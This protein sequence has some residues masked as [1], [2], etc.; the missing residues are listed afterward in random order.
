[1]E[2]V[3]T[4]SP[5]MF[6]LPTRA[7]DVMEVLHGHLSA[8]YPMRAEDYQIAGG[9]NYSDFK[10]TVKSANTMQVDIGAVGF[11]IHLINL[12]EAQQFKELATIVQETLTALYPKIAPV[13]SLIHL[14]GW[15]TVEGGTPSVEA[16][17]RERGAQALKLNSFG[18]FEKDYTFRADLKKIDGAVSISWILQKSVVN[19]SDLY[20]DVKVGFNASYLEKSMAVQ[21]DA[22]EAMAKQLLQDFGLEHE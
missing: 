4:L 21:F 2:A 19:G 13:D 1:M 12:R 7:P 6:T 10:V 5:P 16:M 18:D 11:Y 20:A 14:H 8:Q 9:S 17:L 15:L 22:A 3:Q